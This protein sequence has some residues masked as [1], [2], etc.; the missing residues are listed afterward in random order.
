ML[1]RTG[2]A[3]NWPDVHFTRPCDLAE[4]SVRLANGHARGRC[5]R[6]NGSAK[7][8][9]LR[10]LLIDDHAMFREGLV[11]L[12]RREEEGIVIDEADSC[13]AAL[14]YKGKHT[15][16]LILLDL[17]LPGMRDLE[18]LAV[19][20]DAFPETPVVVLSGEENP[21]VVRATIA[22]GAMGFV[23]KTASRKTLMSAMQLILDGGVCLPGA[24]LDTHQLPQ[25]LREPVA[26]HDAAPAML[27]PRQQEVLGWIIQGKSN[28]EIARK[29]E[30]VESTVK[31]HLQEIY[32]ALGV[33]NRTEAVFAAGKLGWRL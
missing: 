9:T 24:I 32:G 23:P 1:E 29:L 12:L 20:R 22:N 8:T 18:A 6:A 26:Q 11:L 33:H 31:H 16:D 2:T 21:D 19:T 13:A 14:V 5:E 4:W 27:T 28:K 3:A 10:L 25:P 7:G 15:Y 30:V 17:K